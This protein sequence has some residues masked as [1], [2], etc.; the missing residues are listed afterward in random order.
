MRSR[1]LAQAFLMRVDM[2]QIKFSKEYKKLHGQ[3]CAMLLAVL[4]IS[5]DIKQDKELI[6]Y[7]TTAVDGTHYPLKS[8]SYLQLIFVGDKRI[9]FCTIRSNKPALNGMKSKYEYYKEKIGQE[10][11]IVR[12]WNQGGDEP[13]G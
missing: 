1:D 8:G 9:P 5:L 3:N 10:F 12:I 13:N 2:N 7:D 11:R 4:P 6:E